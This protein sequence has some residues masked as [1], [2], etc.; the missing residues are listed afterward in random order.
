MENLEIDLNKITQLAIEQEEENREFN[1][2][3]K[4]IQDTRKIDKI[5]HSLY[6]QV[7]A[8][9]DCTSCGNCCKLMD[10]VFKAKDIAKLSKSIKDCLIED[11][12][13]DFVFKTSPCLL[14]KETKCLQYL[15]RPEGCRSY[16][17]L[18]RKD[19]ISRLAEVMES[20]SICPIVFNVYEGLKAKI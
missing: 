4:S 13:E 6:K 18:D 17:H 3:L 19:F 10:P 16:P 8:K 12:E 7:S 15:S 1:S 5:V 14:L 2:F 9:I 11:K 20:Y